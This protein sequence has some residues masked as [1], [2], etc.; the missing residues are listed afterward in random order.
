MCSVHEFSLVD[1]L[2]LLMGRRISRWAFRRRSTI[3]FN[4]S[5]PGSNI[6]N[7]R[8]GGALFTRYQGKWREGGIAHR[9]KKCICD[10]LKKPHTVEYIAA[11]KVIEQHYHKYHHHRLYDIVG[12][13]TKDNRRLD[14]RV[15]CSWTCKRFQLNASRTCALWSWTF[16][17]QHFQKRL[18]PRANWLNG[19]CLADP[20]VHLEPN[21]F[22]YKHL[23]YESCQLP[24]F[25]GLF[26][27]R[28]KTL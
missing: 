10:G 28:E 1:V 5:N 18:V 26:F 9:A 19:A 7:M 27:V 23:S 13:N 12:W 4:I 24:R 15:M 16:I 25:F 17:A 14:I 20:D 22:K 11:R 3:S 2:P 6:I 8:G 21:A